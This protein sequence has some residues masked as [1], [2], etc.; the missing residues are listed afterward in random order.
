[1]QQ[2]LALGLTNTTAVIAPRIP[3][4]D[5][6]ASERDA[7]IQPVVTQDAYRD[8]QKIAGTAFSRAFESKNPRYQQVRYRYIQDQGNCNR[9]KNAFS[10]R[11][12]MPSERQVRALLT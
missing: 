10:S 2:T 1:M 4:E 6:A 3:C 8:K 9:R 5:R 7:F 11:L 12:A